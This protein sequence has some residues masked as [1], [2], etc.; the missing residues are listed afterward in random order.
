M[1]NNKI[2]ILAIDD[3]KDF[4][5]MIREYFEVRGYEID[6]LSDGIEG[7]KM[8][9]EK[10]Y[11]VVL[12]DLKMTGIDGEEVMRRM[13][14]IKNNIKTIFITAFSDSGATKDRV[15]ALGAYAYIEKPLTSLKHLE[16]LI[17]TAA[18]E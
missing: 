8:F 16:E 15:V 11:D 12:L 18:K 6:A 17:K 7:I 9:A 3:E 2:K 13:K 5:D 14:E 10:P 4:I 1:E